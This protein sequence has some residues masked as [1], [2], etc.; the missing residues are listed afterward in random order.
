MELR[1]D[2][3]LLRLAP[4]SL[5]AGILLAVIWTC[6]AYPPFD[7]GAPRVIKIKPGA[8]LSSEARELKAAHAIRSETVFKLVAVT[9]GGERGLIAGSYYFPAP[10]NV[11][12]IASRMVSGAYETMKEYE[13]GV[14]FEDPIVEAITEAVIRFESRRNT[15]DATHIK[16]NAQ[17]FSGQS[18]AHAMN[19]LI[20]TC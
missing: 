15:F 16:R 11:F 12:I 18:F 13:H 3:Y 4:A 2:L 7:F 8:T 14:F 1:R 9:L 5:L 6:T 10:Q 17:A 19:S 20:S